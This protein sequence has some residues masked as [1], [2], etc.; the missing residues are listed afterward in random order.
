LGFSGFKFWLS[1][2]VFFI[3]LVGVRGGGHGSG[4]CGFFFCFIIDDFDEY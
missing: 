3:F 1:S 4:F 2:W